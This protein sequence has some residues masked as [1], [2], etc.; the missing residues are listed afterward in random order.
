MVRRLERAVFKG[1]KLREA[2]G[3]SRLETGAE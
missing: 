1:V 2:V 3:R